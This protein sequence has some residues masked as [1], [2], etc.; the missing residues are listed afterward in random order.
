ML[1]SQ[2]LINHQAIASLDPLSLDKELSLLAKSNTSK[3]INSLHDIMNKAI[4]RSNKLD[5]N[6]SNICHAVYRDLGF[7]MSSLRKFGVKVCETYPKLEILLLELADKT[8]TVPRETSYHYGIVNPKGS[9]QRTF[10]DYPDEIGLIDGVRIFAKGLEETL[11]NI[12]EVYNQAEE[13]VPIKP[14]LTAIILEKF[15]E[16]L[17]NA[18]NAMRRID[19]LIFSTK[20]RPF[21]D[22]IKINGIEYVGPGGGQV[23]L[24]IIDNILFAFDLSDDHI[25]RIFSEE[26]YKFLTKELIQ[27]YMLY[28][29][30]PSLLSLAQKTNDKALTSFLEEFFNELI[31]YRQ[32]HYQVAKNALSEQNSG[33]YE[34]GSAGYRLEM[35][36]ETLIVTKEAKRR[37]IV[38]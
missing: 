21:F 1:P 5:L 17:K 27:T 29:S 35:V 22:P 16:T 4:D 30:K 37:L 12:L 38:N 25:F 28:K 15:R 23:P 33:N 10:T 2:I 31:K 14:S 24:L 7:V 36:Y 20:L 19:P 26:G 6:N 34:T 13:G 18:G 9:R 11:I 3:D 8:G 32:I